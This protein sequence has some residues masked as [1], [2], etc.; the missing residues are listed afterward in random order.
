MTT[1]DNP[2]KVVSV[3]LVVVNILLTRLG[4]EGGFFY[5][6]LKLVAAGGR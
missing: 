6:F 4:N 5:L 1:Y 3:V 2:K